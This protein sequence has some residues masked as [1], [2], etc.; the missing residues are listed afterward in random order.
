M[1][2]YLV[3][4]LY[5]VQ[6]CLG[7]DVFPTNSVETAVSAIGLFVGGLI[8]ANIFGELAMIFSELDRNAKAFGSKIAQSNTAMINLKLPFE[9][10]QAVRH[11][12]VKN[13]PSLQSQGEMKDFLRYMKPS[14]IYKI[15]IYQYTKVLKQV[16]IFRNRDQEIEYALRLIKIG[17]Y[18]PE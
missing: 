14:M 12:I 13:E 2:K 15:H 9:M 1:R 18:E 10:Q 3:A 8:N 11:D 5:S 4:L 6:A 17:F 16:S 7:S